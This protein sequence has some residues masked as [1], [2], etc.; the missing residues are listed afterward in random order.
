MAHGLRS[1]P[2]RAD[3]Y[4]DK[5]WF[6]TSGHTVDSGS[7]QKGADFVKA[8][9][10]GFD[11]N[12]RYVPLSTPVSETNQL[13]MTGFS[14]SITS[15]WYLPRFLRNQRCKDTTWRP[16]GTSYRYVSLSLNRTSAD[17]IG[18]IAGE[19]GKVKFSIENAS[20]TR[21]VLAD[22]YVL[23]TFIMSWLGW[24]TGTYIS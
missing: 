13:N 7:I 5:C 18:R 12:V 14:R 11:V 2:S 1:D 23:S 10:L 17:Q 8:Y 15:R 24:L 22:T 3:R 9:V 20:R 19:G 4:A 16:S 21:I 6:Q